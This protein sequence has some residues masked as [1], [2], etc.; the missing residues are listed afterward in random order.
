LSST[1]LAPGQT[2]TFPLVFANPDRVAIAYTPRLFAG[3]P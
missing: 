2:V 1:R 3:R